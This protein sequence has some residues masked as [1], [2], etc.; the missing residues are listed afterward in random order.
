M[1]KTGAFSVFPTT[2]A[3]LISN[4]CDQC[5]GFIAYQ[6]CLRVNQ[7][8]SFFVLHTWT[9]PVLDM[10]MSETWDKHCS[11]PLHQW[12]L[13]G[14]AMANVRRLMMK[15][16]ISCH[17]LLTHGIGTSIIHNI[18]KTYVPLHRPACLLA[19]YLLGPKLWLDSVRTT[20]TPTQ[21]VPCFICRYS[22]WMLISGTHF[23]VFLTK[24]WAPPPENMAKMV[25]DDSDAQCITL[26]HPRVCLKVG[27][28]EFHLVRIII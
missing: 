22:C 13:S 20:V 19:F 9:C 11:T 7:C 10:I 5:A 15:K 18:L 14:V 8:E 2:I 23:A 17:V 6:A 3:V 12:F 28:P 25:Q 4:Q 21:M 27:S 24:R 1:W 16:K 26:A